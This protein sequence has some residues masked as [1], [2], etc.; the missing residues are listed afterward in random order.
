MQPGP[1]CV[2][3]R[4]VALVIHQ[5][6]EYKRACRRTKRV[7]S[8][9][10]VEQHIIDVE[11]GSARHFASVESHWHWRLKAVASG[12]RALRK[13]DEKPI[14]EFDRMAQI[15]DAVKTIGI[16][17]ICHPLSCLMLRLPVCPPLAFLDR[18]F[19]S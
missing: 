10:T 8:C 6:E 17:I 14:H 2:R 3:R 7:D 19:P 18:P 13:L 15:A 1:P 16:L 9:E 12:T 4:L 5:R 11:R